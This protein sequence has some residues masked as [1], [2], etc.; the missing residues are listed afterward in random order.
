VG[1]WGAVAFFVTLFVIS[2]KKGS[3]KYL[4]WLA[5]IAA[6]AVT[7]VLAWVW[8]ERYLLGSTPLSSAH[9]EAC[10]RDTAPPP[11]LGG[12]FDDAYLRE[13][14][15]QTQPLQGITFRSAEFGFRFVYPPHWSQK[16]P[17]G[18][19]VRALVDAPDGGSNCNIVVRRV[20]ELA[21][22]RHTSSRTTSM[23]VDQSSDHRMASRVIP[24]WRESSRSDL[25]D[26]YHRL[27]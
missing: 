3:H 7:L 25:L 27:R 16:T 26:R 14:A 12:G 24:G 23:G 8:S 13:T 10:L 21:R 9:P 5:A 17:T 6:A 11:L 19:N 4:I 1:F 15:R 18:P 2:L 20:P 22:L